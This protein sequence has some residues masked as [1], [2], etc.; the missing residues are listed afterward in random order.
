MK[1]TLSL[2]FTLVEWSSDWHHQLTRS[3]ARE[4]PVSPLVLRRSDVDRVLIARSEARNILVGA[5]GFAEVDLNVD[6]VDQVG[7]DLVDEAFRV[8]PSLHPEVHVTPIN[9][10]EAVQFMVRRVTPRL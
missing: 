3:G 10:G 1:A 7:Q 6:G 9:R 2:D 4:P 8:W 5:L